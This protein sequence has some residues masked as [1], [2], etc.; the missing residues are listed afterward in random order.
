MCRVVPKGNV[1]VQELQEAQKSSNGV[2]KSFAG[3]AEEQVPP[4]KE[5]G[6]KSDTYLL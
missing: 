4:E 2:E 1:F 3:E 6:N 5:N